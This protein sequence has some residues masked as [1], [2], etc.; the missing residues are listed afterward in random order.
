MLS[1]APDCQWQ[2]G[3]ERTQISPEAR[4][5]R[6][7]VVCIQIARLQRFETH[8]RIRDLGLGD[9]LQRCVFRLP[10]CR[11][12]SYIGVFISS[13]IFVGNDV[14]QFNLYQ[15]GV[16]L[17]AFLNSYL[18]CTDAISLARFFSFVHCAIFEFGV[19]LREAQ[20]L[21]HDSGLQRKRYK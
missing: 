5:S 16:G 14:L 10:H 21:C 3:L 12:L 18:P 13:R 20:G 9:V 15:G 19:F 11:S 7:I 2:Y 1:N 4:A 6:W 17:D 8:R